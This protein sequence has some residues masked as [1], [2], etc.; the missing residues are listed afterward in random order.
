MLLYYHHLGVCVFILCF[1]NVVTSNME[2]RVHSPEKKEVSVEKIKRCEA[3]D[4][5]V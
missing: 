1:S 2:E 3:Q 5:L 4:T